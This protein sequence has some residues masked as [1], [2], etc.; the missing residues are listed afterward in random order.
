MVSDIACHALKSG[1]ALELRYN[2]FSRCVE[3][4]AV[5]ISKAGKLAMSCWQVRGGSASNESV[6]WKLMKLDDVQ[7]AV[8][9]DEPSQAPR[10]GYKRGDTRMQRIFCEL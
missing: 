4:H 10:P 2:G 7:S 6:G 9:S 8:V 3:V 1:M 5:G